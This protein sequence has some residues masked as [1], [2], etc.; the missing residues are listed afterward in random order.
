MN[1]F[2]VIFFLLL[3]LTSLALSEGDL[4]R[5]D[6]QKKRWCLYR[7]ENINEI[8]SNDGNPARYTSS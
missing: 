6:G 8:R 1:L 5:L 3:A 4:Q 2:G 7:K